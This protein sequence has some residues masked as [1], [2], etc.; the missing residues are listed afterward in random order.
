MTTT[1]QKELMPKPQDAPSSEEKTMNTRIGREL[2]RK[3]KGKP[4]YAKWKKINKRKN[5]SKN[6]TCFT[7][8]KDSLWLIK[9]TRT[10]LNSSWETELLNNRQWTLI[11]KDKKW[12][13][14]PNTMLR[15]LNRIRIR[16]SLPGPIQHAFKDPRITSAKQCSA[17]NE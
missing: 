12:E 8:N 7:I 17:K 10:I 9:L 16:L 1:A 2:I 15:C 14:K 3:S 6:R 4:S 13:K 11:L 5:W